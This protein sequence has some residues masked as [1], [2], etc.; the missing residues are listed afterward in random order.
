MC[1]M[2]RSST[3]P[4]HDRL[5]GGRLP[6]M[7]RDW[8]NEDPTVAFDEIAARPRSHGVVVSGETIRRWV[9]RYNLDA[10]TE[11]VSGDAA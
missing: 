8:R 10:A 7:I 9:A 3:F 5:L 11:P 4:L 6:S 1:R 2:P